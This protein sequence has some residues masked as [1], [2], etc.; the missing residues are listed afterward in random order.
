[1]EIGIADGENA[2]TMVM[3]A[4]RK[5]PAKEVEYYGFETFGGKDDSQIKQVKQKLEK[6]GCKLRAHF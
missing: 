3:V 6:T 4:S 2:R 5:F 1:M